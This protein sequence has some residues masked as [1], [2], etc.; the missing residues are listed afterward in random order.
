MPD[1]T[2]YR[3]SDFLLFSPRTYYRLIELYNAEIWPA[4]LVALAAGLT[5]LGLAIRGGRRAA[6][7]LAATLAVGW[8]WVAWAFHL[9]RYAAI[10]WAAT[11][12]A[13]AF[14]VEGLVLLGCA[15][16]GAR[17]RVARGAA[18][19]VGIGFVAF[20]LLVQPGVG[21]L[22]GRAWVQAQVFGIAPDPTTL[23]T[24]GVLLLLRTDTASRAPAMLLWM[25]WPIPVVWCVVS[26]ATLWAMGSPDALLMPVAA[27][28]A[29]VVVVWCGDGTKPTWR[30][31][32][33]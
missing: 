19:K 22:L 9:Q 30:G 15:A 31:R 24:L 14:V 32:T 17:L 16:F 8:L 29:V 27:M 28:L 3:L 13:A 33:A 5:L 18:A 23:G 6:P 12:F 2:T 25:L 21:R 11:G 1:W 26:G 4:H 7:L 20:A 10:N